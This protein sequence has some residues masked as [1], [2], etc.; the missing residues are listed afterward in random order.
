MSGSE[1]YLV[2]LNNEGLNGPRRREARFA[3]GP[4]KFNADDPR[5]RSQ[6]VVLSESEVEQ[7]TAN[8]DWTI[9]KAEA[10]E[11]PE[12]LGRGS[13]RGRLRQRRAP[14]ETSVNAGSSEN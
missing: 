4:V 5:T 2:T 6:L 7:L 14:K 10:S 13:L 8:S 12:G 9:R 11:I 3:H 1:Q